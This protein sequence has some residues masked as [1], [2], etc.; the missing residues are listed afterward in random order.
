MYYVKHNGT[1]LKRKS[2][3]LKG[4]NTM[5]GG[6][7]RKVEDD[8][9]MV[10]LARSPQAEYGCIKWTFETINPAL[11]IE[12]FSLT[13]KSKAF[14]EANVSW[15]VEAIFSDDKMIVISVSDCKSFSTEEVRNA[16]KLNVIAKL[17]G[18]KGELAWQYAQ[19]FRESLEKLDEPS[20][21]INIQ[22]K[23]CA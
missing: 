17:S 8:W 7:F 16:I 6:I 3:W 22:L 10:Y 5:E 9:K 20:M 2:N 12:I 18:G 4:I 13:A 11:N 23:N 19:L 21:I 15:E 1:T 14:H